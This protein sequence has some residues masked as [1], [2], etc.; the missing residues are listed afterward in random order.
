MHEGAASAELLNEPTFGT[1][2]ESQKDDLG[3]LGGR[4]GALVTGRY[5]REY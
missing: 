2:S 5:R 4:A 1:V 3:T